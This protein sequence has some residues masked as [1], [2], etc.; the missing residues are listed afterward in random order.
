M[1][2]GFNLR[3]LFKNTISI[4]GG[5]SFRVLF[6]N[7]ILTEHIFSLW[8]FLTRKYDATSYVNP[9]LPSMKPTSP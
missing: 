3:V 2:L 8:V 6:K 4:E 5:F 9:G 7:I 1:L